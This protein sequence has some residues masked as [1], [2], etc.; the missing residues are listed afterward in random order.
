[1]DSWVQLF[2]TPQP[3]EVQLFSLA[4]WTVL[5]LKDTGV[6]FQATG[7]RVG[8]KPPF[9]PRAR[10]WSWPTLC[11]SC[12]GGRENPAWA[13]W[14]G[15]LVPGARLDGNEEETWRS[16]V[17]SGRWVGKGSTSLG[18]GALQSQLSQ[19]A[20]ACPDSVPMSLERRRDR[21]GASEFSPVLAIF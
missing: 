18:P 11:L 2:L 12:F 7:M 13:F 10:G 21:A 14:D 4:S 8:V 1:M 15:G 5:S 9:W 16:S 20:D 6:I 3:T 19:Q 17:R